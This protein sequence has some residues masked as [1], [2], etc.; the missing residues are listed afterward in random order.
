VVAFQ[1]SF[2]LSM[3]LIISLLNEIPYCYQLFYYIVSV[4]YDFITSLNSHW[5]SLRRSFYY[6]FRYWFHS[7]DNSIVVSF[8]FY[9]VL[10]PHS[11]YCFIHPSLLIVIFVLCYI[12]FHHSF[13]RP[14]CLLTLLTA[15]PVNCDIHSRLITVFNTSS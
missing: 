6:Q 5:F 9:S 11:F 3:Y 1:L 10:S 8:N 12:E 14:S 2:Y 15:S 4:N 7:I 13:Y